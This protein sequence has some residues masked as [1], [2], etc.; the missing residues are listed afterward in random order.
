[1]TGEPAFFRVF[2]QV[3]IQVELC[4]ELVNIHVGFPDC[5][6]FGAISNEFQL[7]STLENGGNFGQLNGEANVVRRLI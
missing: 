7:S 1:M 2:I 6:I 3:F 4:S 5:F